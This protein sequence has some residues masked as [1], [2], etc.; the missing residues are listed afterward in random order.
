MLR[1]HRVSKASLSGVVLVL[2]VLVSLL[3]SAPARA[4]GGTL[5][6]TLT[7]PNGA[8]TEYFEVTVFQPDGPDAW[9]LA[10]P[11]RTIT[12]W[13]TGLPVGDF[14]ISLPAGSYRACFRALTF[15]NSETTGRTCWEGGYDV[16]GA[17]DVVVTEGGTTTIT[18][19]LPRE[20]SVR[21]RVVGPGGVGISAYV[22]PYRR[23]P[24]GT[25]QLELFGNQSAADGSFLLTDVDP[26]TY[27]FCVLDVPREFV[28]ECWDDVATVAEASDVT[29]APGGSPIVSFW[30]TRRGNISGT[31]TRPAGSTESI[32][33]TAFRYRNSRWE[34]VSYG[35][36]GQ[37]GDFRITGLDADTYRVC[38]FGF[39][40]TATCWR[41]GSSPDDATDIPLGATQARSGVNLSPGTAGY[42]TGSLPEVYLGAQGYPNLTAYRLVDGAWE[43][44]AV[45]EA[46]PTGADNA[47]AYTIGSLPSGTYV[48]CVEHQD[49]EF[50]PAFP[51]T[52]SGGSPSPRG[53][54]PF[55]VTA[56][57]TTTAADIV[58][59]Q[60][61]EVRGRVTGAT[62]VRVDLYAP[63][64][65]LALSQV[66]GADGLYRFRDLPGGDYHVAFHRATA[67]TSLAAEWWR[68]RRD[69]LGPAG[70]TPVTV[71]GA[72]VAG[73]SATLETGGVIT[74]RLLDGGG[75]PVVGCVLQ[76]RGEDGS[77]AVR[78]AT[79]GVDGRFSIG[80][81][82]TASYVVLVRQGCG[83]S[84]RALYFDADAAGRTSPR[85]RQADEVAVTL[86]ATKALPGPLT[87]G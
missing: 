55:Q 8:R 6:G 79:S 16:F 42:I 36:A 84:T 85:L 9:E 75:D 64:G 57:A 35:S 1:G 29:V 80:G 82:S 54:I 69:G 34:A 44:V 86:G 78:R 38:A 52:C 17:T 77:L 43:G 14:A 25:W 65:R 23:A 39:D 61:G 74:G 33:I 83:G 76:A 66:T 73:I 63:T 12:S 24:D 27:R 87:V 70:A 30:L 28:P 10:I 58:T 15:E 46:Y 47:W 71:D 3:S 50:V 32:A 51:Q 11:P 2:A 22:A 59:G 49:P 81:L 45:G 48:V 13:D 41:Q 31:L 21:G 40:I 37:D 20:S 26:G 7:G 60:A 18:P 56:G 68:N 5:A 72:V 62:G 19:R 4:A 53:G 67:S